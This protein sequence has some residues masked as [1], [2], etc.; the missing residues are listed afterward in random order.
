VSEAVLPQS[1]VST[2][3]GDLIKFNPKSQEDDC[4]EAGFVPMAMTPACY[5]GKLEFETR[6]WGKIKKGYTHFRDGDVIFAKITPCFENGKAAIVSGLPNGF[7][8]GSTEYYVLRPFTSSV[9]IHF[10][11]SIIKSS[12]FLHKGAMNMT[13]AVGHK[14]VPKDFVLSY[15]VALPPLNEQTR[16]ANKLDE[17]LAQINT[18]KAR[19]DA[20]PAIL[21]RF[22]QSVLAAA[23]SGKLTEEWRAENCGKLSYEQIENA[24]RSG[25]E[26]EKQREFAIKGKPPINDKWKEK[27]PAPY[28]PSI[29]DKELFH[30]TPESWK[31]VSLNQVTRFVKDGPHFSPK[32]TESGIPFISGR[33]VSQ[34]G[35]NFYSAKYIS[36]E[37]HEELSRRCKPEIGDILYTKGGTTGIACVNREDIEFNVWVHVAVL[38]VSDDSL[39]SPEYI[40]LAL[41]S[42]TCYQRSQYYTHGVANRDLG[43]KRMIKICFPIPCLSEQEYIVD[44]VDQLYAFADQIEQRV[45]DAQSRINNLTQSI[46]AKTFRGELVPQDPN[47]EPASVLLERI[48]KEREAAAK[49]AKAAKKVVSKKVKA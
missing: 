13:G 48:K 35:I 25:W 21:K 37:L 44:K 11:Y 7:G 42:P 6:Q 1:W 36:R 12:G 41:N 22:R 9:N 33:N 19:V 2:S 46:L 31:L 10:I 3:L 29:E 27:L 40:T 15:P 38:R 8:S 26:L 18:I 17:L 47:D 5:G 43:L 45:K 49:L 30:E 28:L 32:Y 39:I 16:I 34:D 20:I 24:Y 14:R 4:S 23:V